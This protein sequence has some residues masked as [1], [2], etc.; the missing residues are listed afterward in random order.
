VGA[1]VLK[2]EIML[3]PVEQEREGSKEEKSEGI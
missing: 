2:K 1:A 3:I